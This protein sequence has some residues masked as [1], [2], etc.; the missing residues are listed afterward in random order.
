MLLQDLFVFD[1]RS[2][3][4]NYGRNQGM[5]RPTGARPKFLDHLA[6]NGIVVPLDLFGVEAEAVA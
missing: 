1:Y 5:I 3:N 6:D 4:D 2:G